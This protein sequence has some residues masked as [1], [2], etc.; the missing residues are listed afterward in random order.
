MRELKPNERVSI[1]LEDNG[2][3]QVRMIRADKMNALD[4]AMFDTL[5]EA[6]EVLH[7]MPGLRAVVLAGEGRSF[8]AGLDLTS[9]ANTNRHDA[10]PLTD[11]T[12]GNANRPQQVAMLWRKLP[13]PVIAAVHG[14]CF[15]G[16]LQVAS[17]A[18]IRVVDPTARMA[19]MELKWGLVPDMAGYALWRGMVR[20]DVLR[21]LTYTNREFTGEQAGEYGF[22]TIVDPNPVARATA[23]AADIANR[24]PHAQR[25]AKR[26][27]NAYL[28]ASVDE[29]LMAE[30]IEQ[31]KLIGSKNQIEAVMSQMEKRPARFVD[32]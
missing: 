16:G 7:S 24:N 9:M 6:G 31:Q 3:A 13:V 17:G 2:V 15:G 1:H 32:P 27:F 23:I 30:S 5:I 14:V 19:V 28:H 25:A 12:H 21:E 18:D 11:R 4:P 8:C 26:L 20:D 22:A 10:V 29:I